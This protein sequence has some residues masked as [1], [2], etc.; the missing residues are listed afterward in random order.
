M[1][2]LTAG[3]IAPD[4]SL[5]LMGGSTVSLRQSLQNGPVVLAFFK[6]S[7]PVCQ[8]AFPFLERLYRG[9]P[10]KKV[11]LLGV[12]QDIAAHTGKFAQEFGVTFPMALDDPAN[13][14]VS[15]AYSLTNVPTI[16]YVEPDGVIQITSEGWVKAEVEAINTRLAETLTTNAAVLFPPGEEVASWRPG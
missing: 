16:F 2:A 3:N 7:C 15:N 11:S 14:R 5:P 4:F 8:Y 12:S 1:P 9:Y 13:Y 6:V 10:G